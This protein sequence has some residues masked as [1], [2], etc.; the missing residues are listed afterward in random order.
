MRKV[1]IYFAGFLT[2]FFIV[3]VICTITPKKEQETVANETGNTQNS[4]KI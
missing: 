4:T 1:L 3:P 2:I